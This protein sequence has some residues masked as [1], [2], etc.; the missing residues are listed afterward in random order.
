MVILYLELPKNLEIAAKTEEEVVL[1]A[2]PKASG[3]FKSTL[4]ISSNDPQQPNVKVFSRAQ[5]SCPPSLAINP[6]DI[7]FKLEPNQKG[8]KQ[9]KISNSGQA[10]G[11][12][13]AR[14]VELNKKRTR[15]HDMNSLVAGLNAKGRAPEYTE[16]GNPLMDLGANSDDNKSHKNAQR[17]EGVN[18][19]NG[20]EVGILGA[21]HS[22][23]LTGFG[24]EL[25]KKDMIAGVTTINVK[26]VIPKEAE[27]NAFDAII[28]YSNYAYR[29]RNDLGNIIATYAKNGG[30]V[31]TMNGENVHFMNSENWSLGGQWR[32]EN[33]SLFS[34]QKRF[35][36]S[37][38][39]MGKII[40]PS[41]PLMKEVKS[42]T[43]SLRILHQTPQDGSRVAAFGKTVSSR[44]IP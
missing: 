43:G 20:L 10:S 4:T 42:L 30:G 37:K 38:N 32:S 31:V 9:I 6:L 15:S 19:Q 16:P 33:Y 23:D 27:L 17:F 11:T 44:D 39:Q 18:A 29:N 28:V 40:L 21:D 41:H 26:S 36:K 13:E 3:N 14:I 1:S 2:S 8:E 7:E 12:W 35:S 5:G 25:A 22:N 24:K 34:I